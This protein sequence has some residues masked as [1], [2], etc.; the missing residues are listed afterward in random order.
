MAA[1]WWQLRV[2]TRTHPLLGW[3]DPATGE[4]PRDDCLL[5]LWPVTDSDRLAPG[6]RGS[7]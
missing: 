4:P 6:S 7:E 1:T 3:I 2:H 5:Q